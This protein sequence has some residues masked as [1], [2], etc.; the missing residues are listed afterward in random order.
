MAHFLSTRIFPYTKLHAF[1]LLS[2]MRL[3][4]NHKSHIPGPITKIARK[5]GLKTVFWK[6]LRTCHNYS[7]ASWKG[8]C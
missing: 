5:C 3:Y 1:I 8:T 4:S 7:D 6:Y 2:H